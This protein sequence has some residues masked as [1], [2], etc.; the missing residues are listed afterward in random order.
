M[1]SLYEYKL[2]KNENIIVYLE[3][4]NKEKINE[5]NFDIN[6]SLH[7]DVLCTCNK[8]VVS[9]ENISS[10]L[11]SDKNEIENILKD[12]NKEGL[13]YSSKNWEENITIINTEDLC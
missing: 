4:L 2:I 9:I 12:L 3:F 8:K 11:K 5:L 7:W 13:L 1:D 6:V 10:S